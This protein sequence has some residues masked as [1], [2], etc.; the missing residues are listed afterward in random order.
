VFHSSGTHLHVY[1]GLRCYDVSQGFGPTP[2]PRRALALPRVMRLRIPPYHSGGLRCCHTS[3]GT[4]LHLAAWGGAP[5]LTHIPRLRIAHPT[6]EVGSNDDTCP[7]VLYRPWAVKI[8]KGLDATA[9]SKAHVFLKHA[10]TV[11]RRLQDVRAN[12]VIIICK[13]C[14]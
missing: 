13:S 4:G 10:R 6:S 9:C 5:A 1:E 2:P 11:P 8:K 7:L 3:L 14:R 12:R